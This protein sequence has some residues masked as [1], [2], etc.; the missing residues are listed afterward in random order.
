MADLKRCFRAVFHAGG[1]VREEAAR[2]S[3]DTL[4]GVTPQGKTA[5]RALACYTT[6]NG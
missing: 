6:V 1:N 5:T 2:A 3:E 4:L